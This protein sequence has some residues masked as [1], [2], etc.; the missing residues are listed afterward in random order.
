MELLVSTEDT[1]SFMGE[2]SDLLL[3]KIRSVAG[4]VA[5][6]SSVAS[7]TAVYCLQSTIKLPDSLATYHSRHL[8][9]GHLFKWSFIQLPKEKR[10]ICPHL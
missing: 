5:M 9:S 10:V 7:C 6:L 8:S 2:H 1:E 3:Q 4:N